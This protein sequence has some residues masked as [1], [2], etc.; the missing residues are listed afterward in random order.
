MI[1]HD[2][3]IEDVD[4]SLDELVGP[5]YKDQPLAQDWARVCKI[6]EELGET[7]A[8]LILATGQNPRKGIDPAAHE[9]MLRELA[10]TALTPIYAI[11]HH[12]KDIN[13]TAEYLL[14][15]QLKHHSRIRDSKLPKET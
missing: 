15:A 10:D 7:V 8:E 11:Q 2:F 13:K 5:L 4:K 12:T 1:I 6:V 3:I 9:R 14:D